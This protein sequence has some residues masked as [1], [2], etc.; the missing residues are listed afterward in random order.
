MFKK[1]FVT[2]IFLS[3]T[4]ILVFQNY[5]QVLT[6]DVVDSPVA[7]PTP[8]DIVD[9]DLQQR[10][11][12]TFRLVWRT[13]N[14]NYFDRTFSGLDWIKIRQE[15]EPQVKTL[16]TDAELHTLL[17]NM[18]S[19]LKKSHFAII[20]PEIFVAIEEAKEKAAVGN[21]E[22]NE[23]FSDNDSEEI[24]DKETQD[25]LDEDIYAKYGI[26]V[27]LR[28]FANRFVI[29]QIE[30]G[31]AAEKAGLKTGYIIEQ[32]NGV[33]LKEFIESIK[34]YNVETKSF[35]LKI[36]LQIIELFLNGEKD[37]YV[38]LIVLD[39]NDKTKTVTL[40]R[41]K[42]VGEYVTILDGVPEQ[43]LR[44]ESKS[45]SND[46]GYIKFNLFAL[47]IIEKF[48]ASVTDFKNKKALIIDLRG[49]F[50]GLYG[51]LMGITGLLVDKPIELGTEIY[52]GAETKRVVNP[53]KK[54][55]KGDIFILV[56][57]GSFSAAEMF[58]AAFQ[59]NN[60][61]TIIGETSAGEA[62]PSLTK[63]LPTGAVF[64]FP[65]SNYKTPKG[66][67]LEGNGVKPD[68]QTTL[69]RQALLQGRDDQLDAAMKIANKE[70]INQE[71]KSN[72]VIGNKE[73][74]ASMPPPPPTPRQITVNNY[75]KNK[76]IKNQNNKALKI[77]DDF[78]ETIGGREKLEKITN[79]QAFGR[80]ELTRAGAIISGDAE[81]LWESP[82]KFLESYTINGVGLISEIFD[83]KKLFVETEFTKT[84]DTFPEVVLEDKSLAMGFF[85]ILNVREKYPIIS[86]KGIYEVDG[87][88]FHLIEAT[89]ANG[90]QVAFNFDTNTNLLL[91][92]TSNYLGSINYDD[93]KK[94]D[95]EVLFPFTIKKGSI[96]TYKLYE[97][98][99]N[100]N[101]DQSR[102]SQKESC[103]DKVDE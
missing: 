16:K 87:V 86:Y 52:K 68:F 69:N 83:G 63:V 88:K 10:R 80:V 40:E 1:I 36:P 49:N 14:D 6:E 59:E 8:T 29:T 42:I 76:I 35:E 5:A 54:N 20:P 11:L 75:S 13:I 97:I 41:E 102:F 51:S 103:F 81:I 53:H 65:V 17:Q 2:L 7:K 23:Q 48:C 78:I 43:Y 24:D 100:L 15:Y 61:A 91:K 98:T 85:E 101:I 55:F 25:I 90:L 57:G 31:S 66:N 96:L 37:S 73:I 22:I 4:N 46:I 82:N 33:S 3:V 56:D 9:D 64:L 50:G 12:D 28:L 77:L 30:K 71:K 89:T 84:N 94:I 32:I 47:P 74:L 44:F 79:Y 26:G 38:Q 70:I 60:R 18:I 92:R 67:F 19:R 58:A 39:E 95:E 93:Y 34:K 45:L 72:V 62:L 27:D 99:P 21:R